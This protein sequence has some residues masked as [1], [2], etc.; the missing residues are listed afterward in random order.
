MKKEE[1]QQTKETEVERGGGVKSIIISQI[2][3]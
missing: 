1:R 2:I 3:V